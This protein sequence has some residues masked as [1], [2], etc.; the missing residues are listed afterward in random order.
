MLPPQLLI[1]AIPVYRASA[2]MRSVTRDFRSTH[3][4]DERHNQ[5]TLNAIGVVDPDQMSI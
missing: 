2:A 5:H 3:S 4:G 1:L